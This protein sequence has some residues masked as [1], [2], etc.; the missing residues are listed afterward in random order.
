M[1][2]PRSNTPAPRRV[3]RPPG[4]TEHGAASR[5]RILDAAAT[6]FAQLGYDRARMADVIEV[7]GMT[8]G[9][10]Y[11]HFESKEALAVAVLTEKHARWIEQVRTR[12]AA[13]PPGLPRLEALLPAVLEMHRDDHDAWVISRLSQNLAAV[14]A[15]R[16]LAV[17]LTRRWIDDVAELIREA[18]R[19]GDITGDTDPDLLAT[20]LVGAFDGVKMT[21]EVLSDDA[22]T[23]DQRLEASGG[24]L[25]TMLRSAVAPR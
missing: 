25:L 22:A 21:I 10:V 1:A 9:S 2:S 20:V 5:E 13:A 19:I 7:S 23:A 24:V 15:T 12:L 11:F 8:K 14:P 3:G 16:P 6:V 18:Q 17:E 4:P